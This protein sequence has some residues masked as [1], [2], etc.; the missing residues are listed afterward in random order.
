MILDHQKTNIAKDS[1]LILLHNLGWTFLPEAEI[2]VARNGRNN[3]GVLSKILRK[4]LHKRCY[5]Y[6]GEERY[7]SRDSTDAVVSQLS[8]PL[9]ND[10]LNMASK[11]IYNYLLYGMPVKEFVN[12][13]RVNLILPPIDWLHID[14]N[15][16]VFTKDFTIETIG[17][18]DINT[19]DIV[20][21]VNGLPFVIIEAQTAV[22]VVEEYYSTINDEIKQNILNQ[23]NHK[24]SNLFAYVQILIAIDSND[25][26]YGTQ[27]MP[28]KFW[29]YWHEKDISEK[30]FHALKNKALTNNIKKRLLPHLSMEHKVVANKKL[31]VNNQDRLLISLLSKDRLSEMIRFFIV[32]DKKK[33]KIIAR[34]QQVFAVKSIIARLHAEHQPESKA[35]GR[36]GGVIWH[37]VGS[38]KSLTMLFLSRTL[39]FH[40]TLKK[41]RIV[42]ITDR[43]D[44]EAQLSKIFN[45]GGE[46]SSQKDKQS[47]IATSGKRLVDKISQGNERIIFSIINKFH[48][49]SKITTFKNLSSDIVILVDEG[50]R[51][52]GGENYNRMRHA[53]P[54]AF[55][56]AFTGTPLLKN[57]KTTNKFGPIIHAYTMQQAVKDKTVVPLLY[58]ERMPYLGID[59]YE[60]TDKWLNKITIGL[61]EQQKNKLKIKFASKS[62]VYQ[63]DDRIRLIAYDIVNHF[64]NNIDNNLKGQIACDSKLSAI[65]YKKFMDEAGLF[66]SAVV[67]SAPNIKEGNNDADESL[68]PEVAKWWKKNIGSQNEKSYTRDIVTRFNQNSNL[69]IL[70]VVD[71]LLTGFDEPKNAVL[72]IDKPLKEHNLIQAIARVN[73]L[74]P[75][76]RFGLLIDYR[77]VLAEL[78][79]IISKYQDLAKLTQGGFDIEDIEGLYQQ[80]SVEYKQLPDLH[81]NLWQIFTDVDDKK[82][83]EQI[84]QVIIPQMQRHNGQVTDVNLERRNDFYHKFSEF[85]NCLKIAL[86]ASSFYENKDFNNDDLENY[87]KTMKQLNLLYQSSV[88]YINRVRN[89]Y[90]YTDEIRKLLNQHVKGLEIA[91]PQ[92]IYE[93]SHTRKNTINPEN[94]SADKAQDEANI[95]RM[96]VTCMVEQSL[97]DDPYAHKVFS[98]LLNKTLKKAEALFEHPVKQYVLLKEFKEKIETREIDGL[99][100]KFS[101]NKHAQAYYG[102]LKMG[103]NERATSIQKNVLDHWIK[104][105]FKIDEVIN[106]AIAEYSINPKNIESEIRKQLLP[107]VFYECKKNNAGIDKTR[108][109]IERVIQVVHNRLNSDLY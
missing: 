94:W 89:N 74:H 31:G 2:S 95:I 79:T 86:Q 15:S 63:S 46:F 76:K 73:R 27:D 18:T 107:I 83:I 109:I 78:D 10:G 99:S 41:Y 43:I 56:I 23:R 62:Y 57:D 26:R 77:G 100:E 67:I 40:E 22:N 36:Q 72:Y 30:K 97:H 20:C 37:T 71:K 21:F 28:D 7:F 103:I 102:I 69:K 84:R 66:E 1:A 65:K 32:F 91:D 85:S 53:L 96:H 4:E 24:I 93:I 51:S 58:E 87:K 64:C 61:T 55:F 39:L 50:H 17:S 81:R 49:A 33:G 29:M 108:T 68:I 12:G 13:K 25:G 44:L 6:N 80:M 38:G 11:R 82:D 106:N 16:F 92:G 9:L 90:Q 3:E 98:E 8:S 45:D 104:L 60:E 47:A 14:S 59:R 70:I 105:S 34:Y 42:I 48:A 5:I 52:Q 19:Y 75:I 54:N 88:S 35:V 101:G